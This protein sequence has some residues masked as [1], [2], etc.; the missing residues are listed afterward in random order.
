MSEEGQE[1]KALPPPCA[2]A[3]IV[4]DAIWRDLWTGKRTIIGCFW[5]VVAPKFP[6]VH[7]A[8]AVYVVLTGGHGTTALTVRLVDTDEERAPVFELKADV[9]WPDPRVVME[10]DFAAGNVTFPA[11]G[12][13]RLQVWSGA[14]FLIERRIVVMSSGGATDP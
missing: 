9:A 10:L 1:K 14:D 5:A 3:L 7:P 11:P 12:E 4:C 6:V 2:L 13:Y 8:M